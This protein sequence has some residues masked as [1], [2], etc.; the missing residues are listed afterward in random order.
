MLIRNLAT[1]A[2][3]DCMV[4]RCYIDSHQTLSEDFLI[5]IFQKQRLFAEYKICKVEA[6]WGSKE[7][8]VYSDAGRCLAND[9]NWDYIGNNIYKA[10]PTPSTISIYMDRSGVFHKT[11]HE[12]DPWRNVDLTVSRVRPTYFDFSGET[13]IEKKSGEW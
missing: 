8:L 13:E 5:A 4:F 9:F 12:F 2:K 10:L 7:W 6:G 1:F 3:K 11:H